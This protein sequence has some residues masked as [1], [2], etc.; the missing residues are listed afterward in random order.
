MKQITVLIVLLAVTLL[1]FFPSSFGHQPLV[2]SVYAQELPPV[3]YG[4][5]PELPYCVLRNS[6]SEA[7]RILTIL[8]ENLQSAGEKRLQFMRIIMLEDD[9]IIEQDLGWLVG[10]EAVW[11]QANFSRILCN[12]GGAAP[13]NETLCFHSFSNRY[14][15]NRYGN[16]VELDSDGNLWV[17]DGGNNRVLRFPFDPTTGEIAKAADLVLGQPNFRSAEPG[18]SLDRFHAPSAV[19]F[20]SAGVMYV[21]R[22]AP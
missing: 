21:A 19:R 22:L 10:K 2:R 1:A 11:G 7:H 12:R 18:A 5:D 20:D 3:I 4:V 14:M 16:G 15:L 13:T 8:G 6:E 9:V 17:V